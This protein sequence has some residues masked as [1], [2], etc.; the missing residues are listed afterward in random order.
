M[1]SNRVFFAL[2]FCFLSFV[3]QVSADEQVATST[4]FWLSE[5]QLGELQSN[6]QLLLQNLT[7]LDNKYKEALKNLK[8]QEMSF[9]RAQL[10]L[11]EMETSYFKLARKY[12]IRN[13]VI[14]GSVVLS[15][16]LLALYLTK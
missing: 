4:I 1:Q 14:S 10:L 7:I 11:K 13:Y 16:G 15:V 8:N 6:N 9:E 2:F 5:A 12:K 3:S